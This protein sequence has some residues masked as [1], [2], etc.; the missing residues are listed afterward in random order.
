M[1]FSKM[2]PSN[3]SSSGSSGNVMSATRYTK[4]SSFF[5]RAYADAMERVI[6]TKHGRAPEFRPSAFPL[7]PV[8]IYAKLAV[9]AKD[10][11]YHSSMGAAGGFFTSVGTAAHE[12]IQYYL[13]ASGRTFGDWKCKNP[14]CKKH[15][16]SKTLIAEDGSVLR[17]GK[18]TRTNTTNNI[19]PACEHSM[20]Y[21]EKEINYRGC[22]GHVDCIYKLPNGNYWVA[23][24]KTTTKTSLKSGKLP[25]NEHL[26]QVPTYCYALEKEY[27]IKIEGFSLLYFSRD[28]PFEFHEHSEQW[29][30]RWRERTRIMLKEQRSRYKAGLQAFATRDVDIAIRKKPCQ[31]PDDYS[32]VMPAYEPCPMEKVCFSRSALRTTLKAFEYT[33]AQKYEIIARLPNSD[34]YIE[35]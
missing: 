3:R 2:K 13:G 33:D 1:S 34:L 11:Y 26:M 8:L 9:A 14:K 30:K 17:H 12:N 7:C 6:E 27:G 20:E 32:R 23:D 15:Q 25:K 5:G 31:C 29:D 16:L 21:V 28:N 22:K 18:L 35:E 10:G 24:Y 19:C 4:I